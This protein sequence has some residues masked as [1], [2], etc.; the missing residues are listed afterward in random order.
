MTN[1]TVLTKFTNT[2]G[3]GTGIKFD[4]GNLPRAVTYFYV[5]ANNTIYGSPSGLP[6]MLSYLALYGANTFSGAILGFPIGLTT[7]NYYHTNP[8]CGLYGAMGDF[9]AGLTYLGFNAAVG[10]TGDMAAIGDV[11]KYVAFNR[12]AAKATYSTTVWP[13]TMDRVYYTPT[14]G[15]G[16][17]SAEVDQFLIDLAAYC[18]TWTGYKAVYLAGNNAPRTSASA[19]A[20]ATLLAR[21]VAV[22][23]N[24]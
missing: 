17:T 19:A 15:N 22:T 1:A 5:T 14:S 4:V 9:P 10:V 23:T 7:L 8:T 2:T 21:G 24:L 3:A 6:P 16:L 11:C 13:S 20:V 18:T 12:N